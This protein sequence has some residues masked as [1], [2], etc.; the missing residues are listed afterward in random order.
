LEGFWTTKSENKHLLFK[1][2]CWIWIPNDQDSDMGLFRKEFILQSVP[3]ECNL[4]IS[5][6]SRYELYI[7]EVFV[8]TGPARCASHHQSYDCFEISSVLRKGENLV[9]VRVHFQKGSKSY[10]MD[11][12]GGLLLEVQSESLKIQTDESWLGSSDESWSMQSPRSSRF[13]HDLLDRVDFNKAQSW[14]NL[15]YDDSNWSPVEVL[16]RNTGWPAP[17]IDERATHLISPW[18]QL[19]PRDIPYVSEVYFSALMPVYQTILV[20]DSCNNERWETL[21]NVKNFSTVGDRSTQ[22]EPFQTLVTDESGK[23]FVFDMQRFHNGR[24][25]IKLKAPVGTIVDIISSPFLQKGE[26]WPTNVAAN[27][28][29]RIKC[30]GKVDEWASFYIKPVRWLGIVFRNLE[31]VAKLYD[32][33]VY[34]SDYPF[35]NESFLSLPGNCEL[36]RFWEASMETIRSCTVDAYTDNYRERR[37]YAQTAYYASLG[38]YPT[39]GDSYLQRRYLMQ[40]AQERV[41]DGLMPAYAPYYDGEFMVILDSNCFWLKGI[42]QYYFQTADRETIESLILSAL[43]LLDFLHSFCNAQGLIDSPPYAYW[44]DHAKND[45]RGANFCLNAHYLEAIE[46]IL[47]V[48]EHVGFW[49]AKIEKLRIRA[50]ILRQSMMELFWNN[51][52]GLYVDC[53]YH[54]VQSS[55]FSEH[56]NAMALSL[57]I[58]GQDRMSRIVEHVLSYKPGEYVQN[59]ENGLYLVTPA[60]SYYLHKG[61]CE[62]GRIEESFELLQRRFSH[63]FEEG[64]NGTLWEEWWLKGTGRSGKY[65]EL[66]H[67][68][69]DAQTESAFSPDLIL[70][71][72]LGFSIQE[73]GM[74]RI[75]LK[76]NFIKFLEIRKARIPS[77]Y[78]LIDLEW[79]HEDDCLHLNISMPEQIELEIDFESVS[80]FGKY[81]IRKNGT[82]Y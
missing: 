26:L 1:K 43:E 31:G 48:L 32:V 10:Y 3:K 22:A 68:R 13:N 54:G 53:Y 46:G 37:Q 64:E 12:R 6:S 81:Q 28:V 4:L 11:C 41:G 30:S 59:V 5:A 49:K 40:I 8:S 15:S 52:K 42:K 70:R 75:K 63:M 58:G 71:Y 65:Q 20:L 74:K 77:S 51:E 76:Y 14:S 25:S 21:E 45:R 79:L 9:S 38:N 50:S 69:S 67:G 35:K 80:R 23:A 34:S 16:S 18:T 78:G 57:S 72:I 44:L 60:M 33:G 82:I 66:P 47:D 36:E 56:A 61:L 55:Q 7:N 27:L 62:Q 19:V 17:Q 29:D 73:P 39:F 2:A 24:P